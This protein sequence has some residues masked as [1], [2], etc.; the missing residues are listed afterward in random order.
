MREIQV[1]RFWGGNM[2][3][4]EIS[5]LVREQFTLS[6]TEIYANMAVSLVISMTL[7]S[8]RGFFYLFSGY[9]LIFLSPTNAD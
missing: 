4:Q 6:R 3:P 5:I 2:F 1:F 8:I 9:F 7:Q